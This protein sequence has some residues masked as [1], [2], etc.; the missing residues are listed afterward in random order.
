MPTDN[1]LVEKIKN[2]D[3]SSFKELIERYQDKVYSIALGIIGRRDA[4][5]DIAQEIWVR[6]NLLGATLVILGLWILVKRNRMDNSGK[7]RTLDEVEVQ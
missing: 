2:G 5:E 7:E 1:Q 3:M 6:N 4:A